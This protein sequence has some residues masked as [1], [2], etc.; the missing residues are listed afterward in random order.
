MPVCVA[1]ISALRVENRQVVVVILE[2]PK[3]HR[4][5]RRRLD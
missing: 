3:Q 4:L 2:L 1:S 5:D